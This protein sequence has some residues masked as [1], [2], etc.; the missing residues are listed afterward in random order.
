MA[1]GSSVEATYRSVLKIR[2][3]RFLVFGTATSETGDW[4]YN[5]A[6]LVYVFDATG[7]A[8][9]VGAATIGRLV[10]YVLLS[11]IGGLVADRF[12]RLHVMQLSNI[13]RLVIFTGM[14]VAVVLQASPAVVIVLAALGTASGVAY[15]P[16]SS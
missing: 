10:P 5:I 13:V 12:E 11:P 6:L 15:R 4:M 14:T 3:F 16:A 8:A 1:D 7:S 2:N 9:W